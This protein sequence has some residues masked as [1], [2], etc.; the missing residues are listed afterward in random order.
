MGTSAKRLGLEVDDL[1]LELRLRRIE[2]ELEKRVK[3]NLDSDSDEQGR[4]RSQPP[5][6]TGFAVTGRTPGTV[7]MGWN[8]SQIPDLRRYQIQFAENGGFSV[9][10]QTFNT[11]DTSYTFSTASTQD[12]SSGTTF[13]TRVRV[14]NSIGQF[15]VYSVVI[16]T[17]TGEVVGSDIADDAIGTDQVADDAITA[18]KIDLP[19]LVAALTLPGPS[20]GAGDSLK[21]LRANAAANAYEFVA[22]TLPDLAASGDA[23]KIIRVAG[24]NDLDYTSYTFP[25]AAT[26]ANFPRGNGTNFVNQEGTLPP[27]AVLGDVDKVVRVSAADTLAYFDQT[28]TDAAAT[29]TSHSNRRGTLTLPGGFKLHWDTVDTTSGVDFTVA[30]FTAV[31]SVMACWGEAAGTAAAVKAYISTANTTITIRQDSGANM[32]VTY[33]AIEEV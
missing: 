27:L 16:N 14:Q 25:S 8:A 3:S 1:E 11:R 22:G 31:R 30:T 6:I 26:S 12:G 19:S 29:T 18:D 15:S 10:A 28:P 5:Q 32:E 21:F 13:F 23:G 17:T 2:V 33:W 7:T 20:F 24:S 9:N 4:G